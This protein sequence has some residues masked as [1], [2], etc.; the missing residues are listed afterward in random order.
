MERFERRTIRTVPHNGRGRLPGPPDDESIGELLREI[1]SDASLL[2]QQEIALARAEL[3]GVVAEARKAATNLVMAALLA[4]PGAL[5][6]TAF[7]IIAIG[8]LIDSYWGSALIVGAVLLG[9]AAVLAR[10]AASAVGDG[11]EAV[12]ETTQSL[13]DDARWGKE[14]LRAFKRELT[15]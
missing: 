1:T 9:I 5:A 10:R 13:R 4:I 2:V 11:R 15:A 3:Q 8:D 14:E 12:Q 6:L 7:L